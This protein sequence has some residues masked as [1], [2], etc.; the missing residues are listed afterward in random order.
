MEIVIVSPKPEAL[1]AFTETLAAAGCRLRSVTTGEAAAAIVAS[2]PPQLCVVDAGLPDTDPFDLV[3]RLMDTNALVNTAVVSELCDED[4][5]E[6]GEGL[7][8]L[9]RLPQ[10][11]GPSEAQALLTALRAVC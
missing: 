6:A 8:I 7:G 2:A 5:H 3:A 4:F 1:A 9:M 11:P 10:N